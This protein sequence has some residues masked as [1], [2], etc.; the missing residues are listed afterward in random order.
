[1]KLTRDTPVRVGFVGAGAVATRHAATLRT[2]PDVR[3]VAVADPEIERARALAAGWRAAVHIDVRDMLRQQE[4]DALYICVPP[5]A[6]GEPEAAALDAG[7]PFFVEKPLAC[8]VTTAEH[9]ADAVARSG[10]VTAVG[11]HWRYLDTVQQAAELLQS[12]PPRLALGYWLD[13]VPP[14]AWWSLRANS[15]GQVVEQATHVL[16]LA[17]VLVGEVTEVSAIAAQTPRTAYPDADVDDVSAATLRFAG[18]A[19]GTLAATCLLDWKHQAC[20]QVFADGLAIEVS[21]SN[22]TVDTGDG[23]VEVQPQVDAKRRADRAFVDAVRGV[24]ERVRTPYAEALLTHRLA[25]SI[26]RAAEERRPVLVG[27]DG[28]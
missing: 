7:V 13:K 10:L 9:I 22:M 1:M 6:H 24:A 21:E 17:R 27:G 16:D 15:G 25:C 18:G 12:R 2:F 20:L 14:P 8:D 19:V 23:R 11:Y 5:F 3:L 4:P 28:G 26:A